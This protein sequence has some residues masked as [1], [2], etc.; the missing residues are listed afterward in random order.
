MKNGLFVGKFLAYHKGHQHYINKFAS[1]C[2]EKLNLILSI[3]RKDVINSK[4][5][6]EWLEKDLNEGLKMN[7]NKIKLLIFDESNIEPYPKG[8]KEWCKEIKIL[9]NNNIDVMFGNEEYV[10]HCADEF[11]INYYLEDNKRILYNISSGKI[12]N[13][14]LKYYDYLCD[15]SKPF[16]NKKILLLGADLNEKMKLYQ[17]LCQYFNIKLTQEFEPIHEYSN[18]ND[19]ISISQCQH[20]QILDFLKFPIKFIIIQNDPFVTEIYSE[21]FIHKTHNIITNFINTISYDLIFFLDYEENNKEVLSKL[22]INKLNYYN[23]DYF[24]IE[25]NIN[26]DDKFQQILDIIV[27]NFNL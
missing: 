8:M 9:L 10:I 3:N 5:R 2:E 24:I 12:I 19:Y 13:N 17:N 18:I 16:F 26:F 6:K 7:A 23:K 4:I 21:L 11:G 1:L 25:S 22:I 14:K 27:N 20:N 15:V